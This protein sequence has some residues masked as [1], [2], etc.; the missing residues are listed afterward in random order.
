MIPA[1]IAAFISLLG[2]SVSSEVRRL[3]SAVARSAR[4]PLNQRLDVLLLQGTDEL[5]NLLVAEAA[6]TPRRAIRL[7]ITHI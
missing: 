2:T 6:L 4:L 5:I 1:P 3:V 7:Q